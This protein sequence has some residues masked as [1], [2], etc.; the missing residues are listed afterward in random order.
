[1]ISYEIIGDDM[2]AVVLTL[3]QNDVIRAEAGAMMY[4]TDGITMD[5]KMD[6][7][8]LGGL[9]R[10]FLSGESF[11]ITYF[12]CEAPAGRVAFAAPFPG[13]II[14]LDLL[15]S[16][17]MCQK[18]SFLCA[19]RGVSIGIAFQKKLGVGLFGGE[20]FIMQKLDGDGMAF[21]HAG[22]IG[23]GGGDFPS[24]FAVFGRSNGGREWEFR[25]AS[26]PQRP[27][28]LSGL[29]RPGFAFA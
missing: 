21:L 4:M 6:G 18:D 23:P 5:A 7:G 20:G 16:A 15:Q 25:N 9:K 22:G 8:V 27:S 3:G 14:S 10:A 29:D 11:F 24:A 2:Q 19:A 1:M 28:F 26:F 12:S 13:K 17:V